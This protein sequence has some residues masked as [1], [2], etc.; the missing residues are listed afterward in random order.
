MAVDKNRIITDLIFEILHHKY[1]SPLI[2]QHFNCAITNNIEGIS[3]ILQQAPAVV[4][5]EDYKMVDEHFEHLDNNAEY[6]MLFLSDCKH[7]ETDKFLYWLLNIS[8]AYEKA[9]CD[10][11]SI[12]QE[13]SSFLSLE[14]CNYV[15]AF[16]FS[17]LMENSEKY[18]GIKLTQKD[19]KK[20]KE[21]EREIIRFLA[22]LEYTTLMELYKLNMAGT[23]EG[24]AKFRN[25]ATAGKLK[26]Q[27]FKHSV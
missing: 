3:N 14:S 5:Y 25:S 23:N 21:K 19:V 20:L 16:V 8:D 9:F 27:F 17:K 15:E 11:E 7:E 13:M 26:K 2:S 12:S 6:R 22:S 24:I 10:Y 4:D 1:Y 18:L